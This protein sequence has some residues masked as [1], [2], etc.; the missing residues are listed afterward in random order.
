MAL[1]GDVDEAKCVGLVA[2][3]FAPVLAIVYNLGSRYFLSHWRLFVAGWVV[4]GWWT[5][6]IDC[7]GQQ[8]GVWSFP[9]TYLSGV[10]SEQPRRSPW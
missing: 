1:L 2:T 10:S 9:S 5:V 4:P 7:I 8:Q 6:F 3:F